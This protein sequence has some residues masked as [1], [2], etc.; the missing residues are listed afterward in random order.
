MKYFIPKHDFNA[1]TDLD[2]L[3]QCGEWRNFA[4]STQINSK[5]QMARSQQGPPAF[6]KEKG[7]GIHSLYVALVLL[8]CQKCTSLSGG[9]FCVSPQLVNA[10]LMVPVGNFSYMQAK[11]TVTDR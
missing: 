10:T 1:L 11:Q 5:S 6:T 7:Q 3:I 2:E 8:T 9:S 4:S